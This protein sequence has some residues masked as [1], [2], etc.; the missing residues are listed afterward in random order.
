MVLTN[1]AV[2]SRTLAFELIV[3]QSL[4]MVLQAG[5]P[6]VLVVRLHSQLGFGFLLAKQF[7]KFV[8][9]HL[10]EALSFSSA[11]EGVLNSVTALGEIAPSVEVHALALH[12][13]VLLDPVD[14]QVPTQI[15]LKTLQRHPSYLPNTSTDISFHF[16]GTDLHFERWLLLLPLQLL[17]GVNWHSVL[18]LGAH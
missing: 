13:G 16:D 3:A 14:Q 15:S 6:P 7:E 18:S 17:P 4:E 12:D 5:C 9:D 11:D 8:A 1:L 10:G 2:R